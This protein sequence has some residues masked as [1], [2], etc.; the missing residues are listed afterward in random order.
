[1]PEIS[2]FYGIVIQ[3]YY[4][5]HPP[6]HF[7]ALYAGQKAAIDIETLAFI[8]GSLPARAKGLVIEWATLHQEELR[9]AFRRAAS[10]EP[11]SKIDPLP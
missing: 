8:G 2:R 6:P 9:E 1:M 4:R 7:H 11:P 5:D 10:M 3:L